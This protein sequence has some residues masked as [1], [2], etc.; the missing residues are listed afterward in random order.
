MLVRKQ[1]LYL[2]VLQKTGHE[3]RKHIAVLQLLSVLREG[4]GVLDTIVGRKPHDPTAGKTIYQP[5]H[6]LS[7]RPDAVKHLEQQCA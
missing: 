4:G 2:R 3:L 7:L 6:E 5:L 1:R